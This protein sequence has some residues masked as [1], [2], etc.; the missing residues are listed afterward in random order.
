MVE[1]LA[2]LVVL[3]AAGCFIYYF[4][5]FVL[6]LKVTATA[7]VAETNYASQHFGQPF[8]CG[9]VDVLV[10]VFFHSGDMLVVVVGRGVEPQA[11]DTKA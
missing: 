2:R 3:E 8:V 10:L 6:V 11:I 4:D 7:G 1:Y 5:R 9:L